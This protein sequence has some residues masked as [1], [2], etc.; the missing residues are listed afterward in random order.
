VPKAWFK[1]VS[2][3]FPPPPGVVLPSSHTANLAAEAT[4]GTAMIA[5]P[6]AT[7]WMNLLVELFKIF[8]PGV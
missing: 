8:P 1:L 3:P 2:I 4:A 5:A 6:N 7:A